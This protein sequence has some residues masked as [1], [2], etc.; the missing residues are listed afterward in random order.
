MLINVQ[1][2]TGK[3][4]TLQVQS[5][6]TIENIKAKI[7]DREGIPYDQLRLL[8]ANEIG[9]ELRCD[10]QKKPST[11]QTDNNTAKQENDTTTTA[12]IENSE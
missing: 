5:S 10:M 11:T 12:A 7:Q 4:L 9:E 2:L 1:T 6:D 8:Y 3:T